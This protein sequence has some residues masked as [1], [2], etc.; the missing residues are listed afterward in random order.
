[1]SHRRIV[2]D[3]DD[4]SDDVDD[5]IE[6][7][8]E[9]E[10]SDRKRSR[11]HR[12]ENTAKQY[13]DDE[14]EVGDEEDEESLSSEDPGVDRPKKEDSKQLEQLKKEMDRRIK[15]RKNIFDEMDE[16]EIYKK[17][18][19][20]QKQQ[21]SVAPQRTGDQGAQH[22][23][24]LPSIRNAKWW[25]VRVKRGK[26]RETAIQLTNQYI[27][28]KERGEYLNYKSVIANDALKGNVFIEADK[29]DAVVQTI[30]GIQTISSSQ[31]N[32]LFETINDAV[33]SQANRLTELIN[34]T[35]DKVV[36]EIISHFT[37]LLNQPTAKAESTLKTTYS[38]ERLAIEIQTVQQA[39]TDGKDNPLIP[40]HHSILAGCVWWVHSLAQRIEP[41]MKSILQHAPENLATGQER[42]VKTLV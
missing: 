25:S 22:V 34:I 13:L 8:E 31:S 9:D 15:P 41:P 21:D 5:E 38:I 29:S 12:P 2:H 30:E 19:E 37:S 1:M 16:E 33:S 32:Q 23:Q 10:E 20:R 18:M 14:A 17:L 11:R 24:K 39:F 36:G 6:D 28:K 40:I 7:E 27:K 4:D 42:E 35:T 3:D 26:E